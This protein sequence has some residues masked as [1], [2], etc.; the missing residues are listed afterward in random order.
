MPAPS[1]IIELVERFQENLS[2]YTSGNYNE[3]QLR[4]EFIDPFFKSLGWD[5]DNRAGNA[6]AYK[7]VIHEDAIRI[8]GAVK[9]PDY[10]FRIGGTRKFFVEAK[11]PSVDIAGD[12]APAYPLAQFTS[13]AWSLKNQAESTL[14]AKIMAAG[15]PLGEYVDKKMFYGIKTG[16]NEAFIISSDTRV[17]LIASD[18]RSV[19]LIKPLLGGEDIRRYVLRPKEQ[20]IIFTRRGVAIE[21][22]PAIK[23]HLGQ[24]QADLTP[25]KTRGDK[26]GRKPGRYKWYE[27]QDDVAYFA[28][29][30]QPKIIFPD[31]TKE[32][33][34]ISTLM[35]I[36][37]PIPPI[38]SAPTTV[39]C[40]AFSTAGCSGSP[41]AT[42]A[43]RLVCVP[44]STDTA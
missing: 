38:A 8:G 32:P 37:L 7:D 10:C 23:R 24:W 2:S 27:I 35:G 34:S 1:E 16:L 19:E 5:I 18:P 11:K 13:E 28:H 26:R 9:A 33:V 39:I 12:A 36:T 30:E 44:A 25:K 3:T 20:W 21:E 29:F 22:Y 6:E 4:R 15:V 42:S 31:I 17:A 43:S 41:L 40:S 14:Y